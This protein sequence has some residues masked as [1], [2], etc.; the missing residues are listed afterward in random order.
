MVNYH[1][2]KCRKEKSNSKNVGLENPA[3]MVGLE[4]TFRGVQRVSG[5]CRIN[6]WDRGE[7]GRVGSG[8]ARPRGV[9]G[10]TVVRQ[11]IGP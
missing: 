11:E 3:Q 4:K 9:G 7:E 10:G 2:G 1:Q 8:Q 6:S 5:A